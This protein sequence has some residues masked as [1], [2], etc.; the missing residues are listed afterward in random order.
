MAKRRAWSRALAGLGEGLAQAGAY[1]LQQSRQNEAQDRID[2]RQHANQLDIMGRTSANEQAQFERQLLEKIATDPTL[3]PQTIE[4]LL[5]VTG[6][7]VKPGMLDAISPPRRRL[8]A[9]IGKDITSAKTPEDV[10]S[11]EAI[12]S[13]GTLQ[14]DKLPADWSAGMMQAENDPL[15]NF[16]AATRDIGEQASVKRRS[17]LQR[18]TEKVMGKDLNT[19]ADT[20][21]MFS[22]EQLANGPVQIGPTASQAGTLAGQGKVA[23]QTTVLGNDALTALTGQTQGRI[24]AMVD[25]MTRGGKAATAAAVTGATKRAELAPDI[26]AGEVDKA[27]RLAEGK[28]NASTTERTAAEMITPL[29]G[30]HAKLL[31]LE[32]K[33]TRMMPGADAGSK[34][35]ILNA[36]LPDDQQQY[37]QAGRDFVST[38]GQIKSGVAVPETE[39]SRFLATYLGNTGDGP[40]V[41]KQKQT[42]REIFIASMQ[43]TVGRSGEDAGRILGE[44]INAGRIPM[45]VLPSLQISNEKMKAALIKTLRIPAFDA[46]GNPLKQ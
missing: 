30:A 23:E 20:V 6:V 21:Q 37:M 14:R 7:K 27:N 15:Q 3:D 43:A 5:N 24:A 1:G 40:T 39:V 41:M 42:A 18:P 46:S 45:S 38:I 11:P 36:A 28:D 44:Q 9:T 8:A 35:S 29:I 13:A 2:A 31:D 4:S 32:T 25:A 12:A 26:V 34:S 16:G 17:L 19:G 22:P 10:P 33:G